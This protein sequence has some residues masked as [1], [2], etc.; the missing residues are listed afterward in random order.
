M[1]DLDRYF[2]RIGW[3]DPV[4][5]T[6]HVVRGLL[7]A[8]MTA[9]PFENLDVLM[10]KPP[11][12]E[13]ADLQ[14]KLVDRK[15]GGYCFEHSTLF[16]AVL[17]R[18]GF[19]VQRHSA[20]VTVDTPKEQAPRTHMLLSIELPEGS[21]VLDPGFGSLSP[22]VPV[23]LDGTEVTARP[24]AAKEMTYWLERDAGESTLKVRTPD[25]VIDAWVTPLTP[26]HPID[27]VMANHYT[28]THPRSHFRA[29][30]MMR[31]FV[32]GD[33]V[34]LLNDQLTVDGVPRQLVD[35]GDL[36]AVLLQYFGIDLDVSQLRVPAVPAWT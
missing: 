14:D 26:D 17:E 15:R 22:L 12:L 34:R 16:H 7:D 4:S 8:H 9:I 19:N 29:S 31:M 23:P 36:Q 5:P 30:L 11:S 2:A 32:G 13:L 18:I 35:R 28:A 20:R 21:F 24:G 1:I 3:T 10:G 25:A 27:F 33:T 6:L